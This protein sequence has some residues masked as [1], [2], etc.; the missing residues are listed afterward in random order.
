MFC[1]DVC[2]CVPSEDV[3]GRGQVVEDLRTFLSRRTPKCSPL[4]LDHG[5]ECVE[6]YPVKSS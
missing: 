2:L 6:T 4:V 3:D 1:L 5:V